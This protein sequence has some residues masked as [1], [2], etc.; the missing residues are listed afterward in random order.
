MGRGDICSEDR[1]L[2]GD[3]FQGAGDIL[4]RGEFPIH[5]LTQ[6]HVRY[7][8]LLGDAKALGVLWDLPIQEVAS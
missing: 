4:H 8:L 1:K 7:H 3:E 2:F 5:G 6:H